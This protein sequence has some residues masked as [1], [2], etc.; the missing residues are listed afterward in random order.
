MYLR[1]LSPTLQATAANLAQGLTQ[2]G[3]DF[4]K[5]DPLVGWLL[6]L[7]L[8]SRRCD[9][10]GDGTG[11]LSNGASHHHE[12]FTHMHPAYNILYGGLMCHALL[13]NQPFAPMPLV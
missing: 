13:C 9:H 5:G 4:V 7:L 11:A 12:G 8:S 6:L 1:L 10:A 3:L 2:A